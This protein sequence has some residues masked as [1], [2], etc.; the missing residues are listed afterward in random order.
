VLVVNAVVVSTVEQEITF[1]LYVNREKATERR[2]TVKPGRNPVNLE[3]EPRE[4]LATYVVEGIISPER[5]YAARNNALKLAVAGPGEAHVLLVHGPL[6]DERAL[7]RSLEQVGLRV[8]SVPAGGLPTESVELARYQV[9]LLSDVAASEFSPGQHLMMEQFVRQG[10]GLAMIGGQRGFAPGGWFQTAVERALPVS[11]EV[12]EKGRKQRQAMIVVLDTSGSMGASV[13]GYTKMELANQGCANTIRLIPEGSFFGML[14]FDTQANWVI[15][16]EN[17][18]RNKAEAERRALANEVGGGGILT[19]PA[20]KEAYEKIIGINATTRHI[21]LFSDGSDT[22]EKQGVLELVR[23]SRAQHNVTLTTICMGRGPDEGDLET[24]ARVGGGRYFLVEDASRLPAIFSRE[25]AL[26]G[27]NFI[28]EEDF[29][30][31]A[32]EFSRL[33]E[34]INFE[35]QSTPPPRSPRRRPCC[36]PTARKRRPS[37]RCLPSG[38][39]ASGRASPGPAT[40]ATAGPTAGCPGAPTTKSGSAGCA[41]CCPHPR[42]LPALKAIGTSRAKGP[43]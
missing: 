1:A 13:G 15:R 43:A 28:R 19:F 2:L 32:G 30:P 18:L 4:K 12:V 26:A 27:G 24:W 17:Q 36:S 41:G 3:V 9:L 21:V 5:D 31:A 39:T 25:A 16:P 6:G 20:L 40:R 38:A 35:A 37:A 23:D 22:E 29:R 11:C 33:T 34:G 10:G 42:G 7:R 8:T 14:G